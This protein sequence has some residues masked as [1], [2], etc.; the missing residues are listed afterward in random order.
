MSDY[1][2]YQTCTNLFCH[3]FFYNLLSC[4]KTK[5]SLNKN[6]QELVL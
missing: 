5:D 6:I 3:V 2:Q 1:I 4:N